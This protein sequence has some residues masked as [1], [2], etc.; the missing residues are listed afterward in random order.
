MAS[1]VKTVMI[2]TMR[3]AGLDNTVDGGHGWV[4]GSE[5]AVAGVTV[6]NLDVG[7][8]THTEVLC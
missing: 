5:G 1:E 8:N 2:D 7:D 6:G 4:L 3:S